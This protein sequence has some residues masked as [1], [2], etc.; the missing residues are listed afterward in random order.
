MR[1]PIT[2]RAESQIFMF[3]ACDNTFIQ[4]AWHTH[5][6]KPDG[7]ILNKLEL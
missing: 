1:V 5:H 7:T 3:P 2:T 6:I 4:Q